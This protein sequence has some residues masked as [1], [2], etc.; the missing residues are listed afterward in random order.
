MRINQKGLDLL[1]KWEGLRTKAY[2]D[3]GGIW[4][5]GY[6]HTAAAGSPTPTEGMV[7]SEEEAEEILARD[8][9]QYEDAVESAVKVSLTENQ[10]SALVVFCYN[11][12]IGAF[13]KSTLVRRLNKRDYDA[14]PE[15]LMRWTKVNGKTSQGLINRRSAEVGLWSTT[16]TKYV[17]GE[18]PTKRKVNLR[19]PEIV[20]SAGG[21]AT[22][23]GT[24][25]TDNTPV[26]WA[27]AVVLVLLAIA[28]IVYFFKRE[29]S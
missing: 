2:R 24:I 3:T 28:A 8:L 23:I 19:K 11:I 22:A 7:I 14:V 18:R 4:T 17:D 29:S 15:Q 21:V 16:D 27:F 13:K 26:Q 20:A 9:A 12:G 1:K 25:A 10:F 6:G 5:I